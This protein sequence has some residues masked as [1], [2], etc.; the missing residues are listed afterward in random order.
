MARNS[1]V[2]VWR[3][4]SSE[5]R[6]AGGEVS[7]SRGRDEAGYLIYTEDGHMFVATMSTKRTRFS[8]DDFRGGTPEEKAAAYDTF[9]G[10]CG[11]YEVQGDAVI[12]RIE[13]SSFPNW[14]GV[15]VRRSFALAGNR[16]TLTTPPQFVNGV[17]QTTRIVWE[18]A[19][20]A[21]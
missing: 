19:E 18:R 10:Y 12:H 17:L 14:A 6:T 21:R 1:V 8:A 3:L 11:R 16:L 2:G 9:L 5:T 15:D 20:A 13:V 4:I 7:P